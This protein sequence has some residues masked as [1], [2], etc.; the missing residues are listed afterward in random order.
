MRFLLYLVLI[1]FSSCKAQQV[2]TPIFDNDSPERDPNNYF[3][4]VDNDFDK[5]EGTWK[6]QDTLREFTIKLEKKD[7][8][9]DNDGSYVYDLL[10]GEY[11]YKENN[12]EI[13]N[14]LSDMDDPT[15]I[16]FNHNI[17]GNFIA[18]K[19]NRPACDNCSL[20]ERRVTLIINNPTN[21]DGMGWITLR[22][23]V[24]D[25]LEQLEATIKDESLIGVSPKPRLDV[26][27]GNYILIKEP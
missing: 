5:F 4:D 26:P 2:I 14:T 15:I 16:G 24:V 25:G 11:L 19:F 27:N 12:V 13:V 18:H 3:K 17:V 20:D 10:I 1:M 8:V 9:N 22:H 7:S 21:I 6:Y 23:I